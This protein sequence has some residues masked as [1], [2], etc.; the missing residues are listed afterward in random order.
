MRSSQAPERCSNQR[1]ISAMTHDLSVQPL[2]VAR[3]GSDSGTDPP[4]ATARESPPQVGP[5]P[6]PSPITNPSFRLDPALGLVVIEFRNDAGAVTTSIPSER[7]LQAYQRW[8]TTQ[9]GPAPHGMKATTAGGSVTVSPRRPAQEHAPP[10]PVELESC[11]GE[12]A[13]LTSW[14]TR[15]ASGIPIDREGHTSLKRS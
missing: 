3:T 6:A 9:F 4:M 5:A 12:A 8:Q 15:R 1:A 13:C 11:E 14:S 2:A 10:A 7:Q